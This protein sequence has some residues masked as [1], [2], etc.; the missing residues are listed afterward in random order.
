MKNFLKRFWAG[1]VDFC[2]DVGRT[3]AAAELA[4]Q[5]RHDRAN[6]LLKKYY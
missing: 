4:R 3:R 6:S 5:G 1:F 2:D